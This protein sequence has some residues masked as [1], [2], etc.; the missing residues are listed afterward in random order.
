[1]AKVTGE[2]FIQSREEGDMVALYIAFRGR[3]ESDRMLIARA[4]KSCCAVAGAFDKFLEFG[5]HILASFYRE[6]QGASDISWTYRDPTTEK[7]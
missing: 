4:T 2:A 6:V 1:M 7:N 3:P 5:R